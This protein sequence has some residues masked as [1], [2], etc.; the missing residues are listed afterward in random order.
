VGPRTTLDALGKSPFPCLTSKHDLTFDSAH[1]LV[2]TSTKLFRFL[3]AMRNH[4][5]EISENSPH[6]A[7]T[8]VHL[9]KPLFL[10]FVPQYSDRESAALNIAV[11]LQLD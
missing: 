3:C 11:E 2:V 9:L 1:S 5:L 4:N 7:V 10:H 6:G 8:S